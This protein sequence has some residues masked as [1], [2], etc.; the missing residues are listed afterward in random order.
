MS[1]AE[2]L[3]SV[4][5]APRKVLILSAEM[6]EGH[7]AAAAAITEAIEELWPT[8]TVERY[9]AVEIRGKRFA[10]FARAAYAFEIHHAP[11][12]YQAFYDALCSWSWFANPLKRV[13]SRF[14]AKRIAEVVRRSNPDLVL[15]TYPYGSAALDWMRRHGFSTPTATFIPAF[16]A[17]PYWTYSGVDLHFVMYETAARDAKTKGIESGLRVGA[18]MVRKAF[19]PQP[20]QAAREQLGL[21]P[22][23]FTVLV[24]GGAWGL[25]SLAEAIAALVQLK[26][27]ITILAVCGHNDSLQRELIALGAP[28]EKL[29]V[30]GFTHDMA[31]LMTASD[32]VITNGAGVTV[33]EALRSAR[34]VIAFQPLPGH[35]RAATKVM[36]SKGLA[37]RADDVQSL[38]Q[39]IDDLATKPE[40]Y[41]RL[42]AAG[43][44]FNEG[45][46]IESDLRF[47][48]Q[49]LD[50]PRDL[51]KTAD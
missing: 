51:E 43:E 16:H 34:P 29:R 6:G 26:T 2:E 19:A 23:T 5:R 24:T 12:F 15:S 22:S 45:K 17:H 9:D 50:E 44:A 46:S 30:I 38:V 4:K 42:S 47:L 21:D 27:P 10:A 7:N 37:L 13:T 49:R 1:N 35:G 48:A 32:T 33:L 20:R 31:R 14:F 11:W 36:V 39:A 40:L 18:P 25:G 28:P 8:W 3:P 41:Q